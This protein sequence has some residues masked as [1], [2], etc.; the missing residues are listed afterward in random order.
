MVCGII[1]GTYSSVYVALPVLLVWGVNRG[2]EEDAK[3]V[4]PAADIAAKRA[5][6][7]ARP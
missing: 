5:R 3:L 4:G 7:K 2:E 6:E 1:I